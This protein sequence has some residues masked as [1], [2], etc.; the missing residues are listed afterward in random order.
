MIMG[1][2]ADRRIFEFSGF[3]LDTSQRRLLAPSGKAIELP[4]RAFDVLLFL[5]ERP[6]QLLDKSTLMQAAWPHVVVEEGNLTQCIY[7]LRRALDESASGDRF[8]V[9][10][11]G[12][13]YQ[14]IA[15]VRILEAT[16]P[17]DVTA[18]PPKLDTTPV[19]PAVR[20][21]IRGPI[22]LTIAV[23]LLAF[24][25]FFIWMRTSQAPQ[26]SSPSPS[27]PAASF[28][29]IAVIPFE[30]V[31]PQG[32]M[33][34]FADGIADELI[35]S[36]AKVA[37]LRVAGRTSS[38]ASKGQHDG[39][40]T[41]GEKL[42][43]QH[44]LQGSVR[45]DA[46]RI[47]IAA[48]LVRTRDGFTLWSQTY[49]RGLD[50]V[51]DIQSTIAHEV[52]SALVP[53]VL[54]GNHP[55]AAVAEIETRNPEAYT[56]YLRGLYYSR[57]PEL[58]DASRARDEFLRAVTLDP[59][60]ARAHA[61]LGAAYHQMGA[62]AMGNSA[63]LF[64]AAREAID[65]ALELDP[66]LGDLWWIKSTFLMHPNTPYSQ[67]VRELERAL[68][69]NPSDSRARRVLGMVYMQQGRHADAL[70][71]LDEAYQS[72]PLWPLGI[73]VL[74]EAT[75]E[76]AGDRDRM[77]ALLDEMERVSPT[78]PAPSQLR[79]RLALV[80]GR[81]LDWDAW[82]TRSVTLGPT[83]LA[84]HGY[85]ALDYAGLGMFDAA[86]HHA[87][88]CQIIHP[89]SAAGWYNVAHVLLLEGRLDEARA[90]VREIVDRQP[91]D[92]LA[93]L[94]LG[95]LR[96]FESDCANSIESLIRARQPLGHL[97][98]SLNLLNDPATV[99]ILTWCHR[100]VGDHERVQELRRAFEIQLDP[101][102]RLGPSAIDGLRVRMAAA[103]GDRDAL[104]RHLRALADSPSMSFALVR[105]EPM[106]Q[107]YL[108]DAEILALL[109]RL[110]A[111]RAEWQKIV[112]K[113]SVRVAVKAAAHAQEG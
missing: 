21:S 85:L 51:L 84:V 91:D 18:P 83:D 61:H 45:R 104:V 101:Q 48:Q 37:P 1:A 29:S 95:E 92:F 63:E 93:Q 60:F 50:E 12:R 38:F 74:A 68:T 64:R 27:A 30:D 5:V 35:I 76:I 67:Y 2:A 86:L 43:V 47:R 90:V 41:L 71:A 39:V 22:A 77:L 13:G 102:W 56:S 72:D 89:Q 14:F 112:P 96:Y 17:L 7:K 105:H 10:V 82:V 79:G 54:S 62:F 97:P 109:A 73:R 108:D 19:P 11:P 75:Y 20:S 55:D 15:P 49:D 23:P 44:I 57:L 6:G 110:H 32:D 4:S 113:N 107:P 9:T 98:A 88:A 99:P 34:Y 65:R 94:A 25:A 81:A 26:A 100:S 3:R 36:L 78:N 16:A 8:I 70:R 42:K 59:A 80:E 31:S 40:R 53:T 46:E 66:A 106:I 69:A 58:T 28:Q 52:I 87:K 24:I 111:R 33:E 103:L